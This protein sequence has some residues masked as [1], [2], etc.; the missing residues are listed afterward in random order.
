MSKY[1]EFIVSQSESLTELVKSFANKGLDDDSYRL[2]IMSLMDVFRDV[3][4]C[5][6]DFVGYIEEPSTKCPHLQLITVSECGSNGAQA[7][8]TVTKSCPMLTV[9]GHS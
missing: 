1:Q 8:E 2:A 7:S 3:L 5:P 4:A 6:D 9:V